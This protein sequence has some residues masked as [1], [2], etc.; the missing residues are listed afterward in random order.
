MRRSN[1]NVGQFLFAI[2]NDNKYHSTHECV[3]IHTGF[4]S[5]DGY[6][7]LIGWE[8]G[9]LVKSTGWNNFVKDCSVRPASDEEIEEFMSQ[10]MLQNE[11]I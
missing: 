7:C 4:V 3:F 10:L 1:Y 11:S 9:K 2:Y 8:N 5:S 6:G